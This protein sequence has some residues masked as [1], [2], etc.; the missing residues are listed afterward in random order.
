VV[1]FTAR[2][3]L[4]GLVIDLRD[5]GEVQ[6]EMRFGLT[7]TINS[8]ESKKRTIEVINTMRFFERGRIKKVI[9]KAFRSAYLT[10]V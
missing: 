5:G 7:M 10:I 4:A 3:S 1:K 9:C 6:G 2:S 8:D